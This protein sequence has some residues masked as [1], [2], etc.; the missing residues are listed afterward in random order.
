MHGTFS[1]KHNDPPPSTVALPMQMQQL[2]VYGPAV[3]PTI[4][5]RPIIDDQWVLDTLGN[6][7]DG[8]GLGLRR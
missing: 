3:P 6:S 7:G 8:S 2:Q 5:T 4:D 1:K